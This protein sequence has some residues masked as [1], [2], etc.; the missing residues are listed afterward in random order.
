MLQYMTGILVI[1][2]YLEVIF[3]QSSSVSGPLAS[4]VYGF[5]QLAAGELIVSVTYIYINLYLVL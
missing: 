2:S 4:I 3:R 5:V 1:Q